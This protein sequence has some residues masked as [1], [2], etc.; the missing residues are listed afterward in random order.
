MPADDDIVLPQGTI[1]PLRQPGLDRKIARGIECYQI[2]RLVLMAGC[3]RIGPEDQL[4]CDLPDTLDA[5]QAPQHACIQGE[6]GGLRRQQRGSDI[7]QSSFRHDQHVGAQSGETHVHAALDAAH[8]HGAGKDAAGADGDGGEE[9]KAARLAPPEILQGKI[10]Q[11]KADAR[12]GWWQGRPSI[13]RRIGVS[14]RILRE[15]SGPGE[16]DWSRKAIRRR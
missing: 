10:D 6:I 16:C 8:Q 13:L 4:W 5:A 14:H 15:A 11:E 2:D 1:K 9:E 12:T 3:G 7:G